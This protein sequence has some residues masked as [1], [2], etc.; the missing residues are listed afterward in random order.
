MEPLGC[1]ENALQ[2][3]CV[4][5]VPDSVTVCAADSPATASA[6]SAPAAAMVRRNM[7]EKIGVM[8]LPF[9]R[10]QV[11]SLGDK[12]VVTN[13][14]PT[15]T[16]SQARLTLSVGS[17]KGVHEVRQDY[18]PNPTFYRK[19]PLPC[20]VMVPRPGGRLQ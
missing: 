18:P 7:V 2:V 17:R 16:S 15:K 9:S 5:A 8:E 4:F 11:S 19:W 13:P 20:S 10:R 1:I 12:I 3:H 6:T 14:E